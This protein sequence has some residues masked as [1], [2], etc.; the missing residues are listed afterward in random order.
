[1][2]NFKKFQTWFTRSEQIIQMWLDIIYFIYF[3]FIILENIVK[4]IEIE[5]FIQ[6]F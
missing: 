5:V 2:C 4:N 6:C 3:L 1:M